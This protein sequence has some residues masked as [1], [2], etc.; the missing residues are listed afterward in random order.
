V[1]CNAERRKI[2]LAPDNARDVHNDIIFERPRRAKLGY[3]IAMQFLKL[4]STFTGEN[5][6]CWKGTMLKRRMPSI[7]MSTHRALPP[8]YMHALP[9]GMG[10]NH[11]ITT[12]QKKVAVRGLSINKTRIGFVLQNEREIENAG[13]AR[14]F[15]NV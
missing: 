2:L 11:R 6:G 9:I 8:T 1:S 7:D 5:S 4:G 14:F 10:A 3:Q 12:C 15:A 13:T